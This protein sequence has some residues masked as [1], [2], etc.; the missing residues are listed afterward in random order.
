MSTRPHVLLSCAT[1]VDG[2]L[3]DAS[4]ERLVLS[5]PDDLERV[6]AV[7]ADSDAILVGAGT[8]RLDNPRLIVRSSARRAARLARGA[9]AFPLKVTVTRSGDL[10]PGL[11][12][13]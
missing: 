9:P 7:R 5:G 12:F 11:R 13:W 1:S 3:D 2:Y 10:D 4:A 6:D 8:L